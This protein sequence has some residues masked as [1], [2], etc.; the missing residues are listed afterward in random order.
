[1]CRESFIIVHYDLQMHNWL[2]R[3][4][5]F[6]HYRIILRELEINALQSNTSIS[7]AAVGPARPL[8]QYKDVHHTDWLDENCSNKNI[9]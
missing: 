7:N 3:S 8:H 9:L 5:M 4:Y 1:M 6:R 2:S